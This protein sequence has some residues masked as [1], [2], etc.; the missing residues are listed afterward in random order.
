M[1][2]RS[3]LR[4]SSI[5]AA[6]LLSGTGAFAATKPGSLT[7]IPP[8]HNFKLKYAPHFGMFKN[9]AGEDL[10]DQL[11]FVADVGFTALEDNRMKKREVA[12]QEKIASKM[13][14]LNIEMGVFVAHT[15]KWREPGLAS[16]DPD[17]LKEFLG[18]IRDSVED[19]A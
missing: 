7:Q 3:F 2:R 18:E 14:N 8:K 19:F 4:N 13:A 9:H 17:Q 1:Q 6:A 15:I 11:Q 10:L 12:M 5:A 16:G